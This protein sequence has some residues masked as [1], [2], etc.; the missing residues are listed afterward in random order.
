MTATPA[1]AFPVRF[2]DTQSGRASEWTRGYVPSQREDEIAGMLCALD[3]ADEQTT[4]D[5]MPALLA[6]LDTLAVQEAEKVDAIAYADR[7]VKSEV[8]YLKAEEARLVARRRHLEARQAGF[9]DY[10]RGL[11][12]MHGLQK[13][14]GH[15]ST[16]SLRL[17]A[18]SLDIAVTP[19][20]LPAEYVETVVERRIKRKDLLDAVKA[21][22]VL[23]GVHL[24]Q[25]ESI[26]IR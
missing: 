14:K 9:R 22:L 15:A 1:P 12:L 5:T 19:D 11:F 3:D 6:Y 20:D 7:K 21:G 18:P 13:I 26:T 23:P 2:G 10:L 16:I 4:Q 25:T 17:N 8:E 24:R